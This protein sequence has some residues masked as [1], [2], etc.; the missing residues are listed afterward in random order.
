MLA[1]PSAMPPKPNSAAIPAITRKISDHFNRDIAFLLPV[2]G[3]WPVPTARHGAPGARP[4][5]SDPVADGGLDLLLPPD[6]PPPENQPPPSREAGR[7][8]P[9]SRRRRRDPSGSRVGDHRPR[10]A[11]KKVDADN[12]RD[13]PTIPRRN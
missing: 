2:S 12:S 4:G 11:L 9:G 7:G 8:R 5:A 6:P 10:E 3:R 13:S 1:A